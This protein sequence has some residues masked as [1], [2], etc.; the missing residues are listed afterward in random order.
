MPPSPTVAVGRSHRGEPAT[1]TCIVVGSARTDERHQAAAAALR[2]GRQAQVGAFASRPAA[3]ET[4]RAADVAVD[5][6]GECYVTGQATRD[7]APATSCRSLHTPGVLR[8]SRYWTNPTV[9]GPDCRR[10]HRRHARRH[11]GRLRRHAINVSKHAWITVSSTARAPAVGPHLR[12]P[13]R[14]RQQGQPG[15]HRQ[16]GAVYVERHRSLNGSARPRSSVT[17][18]RARSSGGTPT[19]ATRPR[20]TAT[21]ASPRPAGQCHP[22]VHH[23]ADRAG[24]RL[25]DHEVHAGRQPRVALRARQGGDAERDGQRPSLQMPTTTSMSRAPSATTEHGR[26]SLA[27]LNPAD[28]TRS[29]SAA[30]TTPSTA[31]MW[32][33][34]WP[35]RAA[36]ASTWRGRLQPRGRRRHAGRQ[37]PAIRTIGRPRAV[38][39]RAPVLFAAAP[40]PA[41]VAQVQATPSCSFGRAAGLALTPPA[42]QTAYAPRRDR[43]RHHGRLTPDCV[44]WRCRSAMMSST[45]LPSRSSASEARARSSARSIRIS[46]MVRSVLAIRASRQSGRGSAAVAVA[47]RPGAAPATCCA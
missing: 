42:A 18:S 31:W 38:P 22:G 26:R 3:M 5:G 2:Q 33:A 12:H 21:P 45:S 28:G 43:R 40:A 27:K 9:N 14:R 17:G 8:W 30:T 23:G 24:L 10:L 39:A 15:G 34:R 7:P 47:R 11:V 35:S 1:A 13:R 19:G 16:D 46:S 32:P 4:A 6:R 29:G 25:G 20:T 41:H 36:P 44:A 37:L